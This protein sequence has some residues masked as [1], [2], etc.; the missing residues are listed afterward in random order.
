MK[1]RRL[2]KPNRGQVTDEQRQS[3]PVPTR[4]T[5]GTELGSRSTVTRRDPKQEMELLAD[6]LA[7]IFGEKIDRSGKVQ[8]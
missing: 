5:E 6:I 4:G 2:I 1:R 7:C 8:N 3:T